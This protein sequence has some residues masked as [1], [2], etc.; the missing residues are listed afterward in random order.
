ME[1]SI[2]VMARGFDE[3][4]C[5]QKEVK[6]GGKIMYDVKGYHKYLTLSELFDHYISI[7]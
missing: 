1:E 7:K 4:L 6:L 2:E 3:F 5:N